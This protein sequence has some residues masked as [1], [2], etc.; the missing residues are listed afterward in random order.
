MSE[1]VDDARDGDAVANG[2]HAD[3]G[4]DLRGRYAPNGSGRPLAG[5]MTAGRRARRPTPRT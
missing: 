4:A 3:G 2:W 5:D 1:R